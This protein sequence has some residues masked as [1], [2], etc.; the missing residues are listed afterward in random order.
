MESED[1]AFYKGLVYLMEN[2]VDSLGYEITFS[3]EVIT[4]IFT[5]QQLLFQL[6]IFIKVWNYRFWFW[7]KAVIL[8]L[9]AIAHLPRA[10]REAVVVSLA[11]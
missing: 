2:K 4:I 11:Q 7:S 3:T 6:I 10:L 1:Y 8:K 9:C 5:N